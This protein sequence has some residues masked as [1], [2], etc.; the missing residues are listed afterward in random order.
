MTDAV[1]VDGEGTVV[2]DVLDG[3]TI[4]HRFR[5]R[6]CTAVYQAVKD[7]ETVALKTLCRGAVDRDQSRMDNE[8]AS[9]RLLDGC[10]SAPGLHHT[11]VFGPQRYFVMDW[12]DGVS[13]RRRVGPLDRVE[14]FA[15]LAVPV[16]RAY[17]E[18][19]EHGIA[20]GD[21]SRHN[22]L[23]DAEGDIGLIDFESSARVGDG[24]DAVRRRFTWAYAAPEFAVTEGPLRQRP[25]PAADQYAVAAVLF[26]QLTGHY[27][28]PSRPDAKP[29]SVAAL[30]VR[31]RRLSGPAADRW[32]RLASVL[33]TA[34]R[35][36][37]RDR[38][39]DTASFTAALAEALGDG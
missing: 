22:I 30:R 32:P 39:A 13:L 24:D 19:H 31:A 20:H 2:G 23:V 33:A 3:Y 6:G 21:V 10:P 37:P 36:R 18:L 5:V 8:L 28:R 17:V 1:H 25:T 38:F 11:A 7:G 27:P 34:L 26:R 12:R 16:C 35:Q 4:T 14:A 29:D 15:R 9:L